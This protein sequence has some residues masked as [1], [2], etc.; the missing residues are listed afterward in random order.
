MVSKN[1]EKIKGADKWESKIG[2]HKV[3]EIQK[4]DESSLKK[5]FVFTTSNIR[6]YPRN[7]QGIYYGNV[8]KAK[9]DALVQVRRIMR[10]N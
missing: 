3:I 8:F 2:T 5:W 10:I 6:N 1:W 4:M 7:K 9:K